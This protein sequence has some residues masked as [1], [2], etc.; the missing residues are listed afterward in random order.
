[1][2]L[3]VNV[4]TRARDRVCGFVVS[5]F[6]FSSFVALWHLG[7]SIW[8]FVPTFSGRPRLRRRVA[9]ARRLAGMLV[10][11][12][13]QSGPPIHCANLGLSSLFQAGNVLGPARSPLSPKVQSQTSV[14]PRSSRAIHDMF[15]SKGTEAPA[16]SRSP[17][18]AKYRYTEEEPWSRS[19]YSR[20]MSDSMRFL[21][22]GGFRGNLSCWKSSDMS[23][24]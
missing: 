17:A 2:C 18:H 6:V 14:G 1:V 5:T 19:K 11:S 24:A 16:R 10:R 20:S 9:V 15:T 7:N 4:H 23:S 8:Q 3:T 21:R 13:W 12:A 22:S